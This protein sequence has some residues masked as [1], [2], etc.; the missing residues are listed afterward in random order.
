M[1]AGSAEELLVADGFWMREG[2]FS[3]GVWLL[4]GCP[5]SSDGPTL[6][7]LLGLSGLGLKNNC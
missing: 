2:Q 3:S 6:Y 1:V 5:S 7:I 4:I